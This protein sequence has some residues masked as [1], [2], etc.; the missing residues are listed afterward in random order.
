M[1]Y[2]TRVGRYFSSREK[3]EGPDVRKETLKMKPSI[4]ESWEKFKNRVQDHVDNLIKDGLLKSRSQVV[5]VVTHTLVIKHVARY[6][7]FE[8][9]EWYEFLQWVA[10]RSHGPK[11]DISHM[12]VGDGARNPEVLKADTKKD[13]KKKRGEDKREEE[14]RE[15]LR[16]H[17]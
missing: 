15:R 7:N 5:W 1:V 8:M 14:R 13:K 6:L 17:R 4:Y 12:A 3:K 10:L 16:L 9:P 11:H 2:D